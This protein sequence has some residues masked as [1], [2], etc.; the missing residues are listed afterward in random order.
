MKDGAISEEAIAPCAC[1]CLS[2]IVSRVL[3]TL[4][5]HAIFETLKCGVMEERILD[6]KQRICPQECS[7]S[8]K[9]CVNVCNYFYTFGGKRRIF[10]V[11]V[12]DCYFRREQSIYSFNTPTASLISAIFP[13]LH[14][15]MCALF[16]S[17]S[18]CILC[19][20]ISRI[21]SSNFNLIKKYSHLKS[22]NI[23]FIAKITRIL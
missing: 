12:D 22:G 7:N 21:F 15:C 3:F 8:F 1:S 14:V 19:T 2:R 10:R 13:F 11:A 17:T 20:D 23:L 18:K 5:L 16:N 4:N 6:V 9:E